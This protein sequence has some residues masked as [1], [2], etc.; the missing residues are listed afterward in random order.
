MTEQNEV[1]E[2]DIGRPYSA[3]WYALLKESLGEAG[4]RQLGFYVIP[5]DLLLSVV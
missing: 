1:G 5:D 3:V 2:M 4:C